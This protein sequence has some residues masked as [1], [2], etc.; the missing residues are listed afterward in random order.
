[1]E[2]DGSDE[3]PNQSGQNR[4]IDKQITLLLGLA[5]P[6]RIIAALG[7]HGAEVRFC[8][9]VVRDISIGQL[10]WPAPDIDMASPMPPAEAARILKADDLKVIP[11]GIDHGTITVISDGIAHEIT[12]YRRDVQGD[13]RHA[14]VEF[15]T[16]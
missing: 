8:G 11:T 1:M 9:G 13:G 16:Q 4:A 3:Y 15:S 6:Q 14:I 2:L 10:K 7:H 5:L 12:T